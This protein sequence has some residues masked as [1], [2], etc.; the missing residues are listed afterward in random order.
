MVCGL[1]PRKGGKGPYS[2]ASLSVAVKEPL[3]LPDYRALKANME[4]TKRCRCG[5]SYDL[6]RDVRVLNSLSNLLGGTWTLFVCRQCGHVE[7]YRE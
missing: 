6:E 1:R 7:F 2:V 5:G 3:R 4:T